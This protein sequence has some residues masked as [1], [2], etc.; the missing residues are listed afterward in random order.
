MFGSVLEVA[1]GVVFVFLLASIIC[2]AI[3]EGIEAFLKTRAAFLERGIRELL[4][5][6][7][8][9]GLAKQVYTHP[10]VAGM[11]R[12]QYEPSDHTKHRWPLARGRDLPAYIPSRNFALALLDIAARGPVDDTNRARAAQAPALSRAAVR[13]NLALMPVPVQRVLLT[14]IDVADGDLNAARTTLEHWY[15]DAMDRVSSW[16]KRSTQMILFIIGLVF[17][18]VANVD[19]IAITQYLSH[20]SAAR[21]VI[22]ARATAAVADSAILARSY[23]QTKADLEALKLPIGWEARVGPQPS[24]PSRALGWFVTA[25]AVTMGAPFWFDLLN[26]V[27]AIRSAVKPTEKPKP[28]PADDT[29]VV[30]SGDGRAAAVVTG[31]AATGGALL[32]A[33]PHVHSEEHVDACDITVTSETPDDQLPP[34]EGGVHT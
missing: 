14:A 20:D 9:E 18:V 17:A 19:T 32:V 24:W 12:D 2:S 4:H 1:I 5:D 28:A 25:L 15:D 10:L 11:Y 22:V 3:R 29:V 13:S 6:R 34:A 16:Y 33:A 30:A 7:A 26:K 27:T 21:E 31:G 23:A 8:A